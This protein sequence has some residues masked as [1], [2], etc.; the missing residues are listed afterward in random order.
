MKLDQVWRGAL[1]CALALV[2]MAAPAARADEAFSPAQKSAIDQAIHD[3]LLA[4]PEAVLDALKAAQEKSDQQ[5]AAEAR[6]QIAVRRQELV[7]D[8]DDLV[9]GDPK[10]DATIVEFF[11]YRCPYCK[12]IEPTLDA[13]LL[14]DKRL[15]I[16]YKEFPILGEA[17]IYAA[18]AALASRSQ[19]KYLAFHRAMMAEKGNITDETV[20]KVAASVGLDLKQLKVEMDAPAIARI[21]KDNYALAETLHI[22]GTP[23]I[24]VGDTLIPGAVDPETLRK[25]IAA[26]RKGS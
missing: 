9:Q 25:E 11:D 26:A 22:Q 2:A 1:A 8:P 16:V 19:G 7:A 3:Y 21:I 18:R 24:I 14:E 13:L 6:R 4:H 23:G 17:S 5:A 10:G 12:E 20:L 15:R